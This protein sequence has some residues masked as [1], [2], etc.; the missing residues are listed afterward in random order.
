MFFLKGMLGKDP[1][2]LKGHMEPQMK[3]SVTSFLNVLAIETAVNKSSKAGK[4]NQE[5]QPPAQINI[6]RCV[7]CRMS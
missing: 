5:C 7:A 6:N 4:V 2:I 1:S 3:L